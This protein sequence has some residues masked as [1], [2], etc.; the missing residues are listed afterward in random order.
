[1]PTRNVKTKHRGR[2]HTSRSPFRRRW[3]QGGLV[4]VSDGCS[5]SA[6]V[7]AAPSRRPR[8]SNSPVVLTSLQ[9]CYVPQL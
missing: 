8:V 5:G 7:P 4:T 1:M 6:Q 3:P 9:H 2:D